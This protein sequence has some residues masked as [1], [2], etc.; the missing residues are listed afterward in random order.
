MG[1]WMGLPQL[2]SD[3]EKSEGGFLASEASQEE[4]F[5]VGK[6]LGG[7]EIGMRREGVDG[8]V[9]DEGF[10]GRKVVVLDGD[11]LVVLADV[12]DEVSFADGFDFEFLDGIVGE[13]SG[14]VVGE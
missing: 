3:A 4:N 12:D 8:V 1:V 9:K 5:C 6:G 2:M 11:L 7:V 14:A 13:K 10:F